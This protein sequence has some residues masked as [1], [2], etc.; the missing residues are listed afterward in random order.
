VLC[1]EPLPLRL[2]VGETSIEYLRRGTGR[3]LL[4]L[5]GFDG[6]SEAD[7]FIDRLAHDFDVV[8]PS[9]PGFGDSSLLD[10]MSSIEDLAH[11]VLALADQ[12]E[13]RNAILVGSS[14][15]GWLAAEI[16]AK[17]PQEF[18]QVILADAV[19]VRF[20]V[21]PLE[22]EIQD[23][24]TIA[25][26]DYPYAL[27][28]DRSVAEEHFGA[29]DFARMSEEAAVRFCRNREGA[30]L[31]GW[32]PLLHNPGLRQ[33]LSLIRTPTLVLWGAEDQVVSVGYGAR[34]AGS[35]PGAAF[36]VVESCG[37]YLPLERPD[38]FVRLTR[39]FCKR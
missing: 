16:A 20:A 23:I 25:T 17:R 19:G 29:L 35:I 14:F 5:H 37:H 24:F 30:T 11:F 15:G 33:R 32:A 10:T 26:A 34:F 27:F 2:N 31:F 39:E 9:L 6:I 28:H 18:S 21:D 13:L 3:S 8:A 4:Y 1:S 7:P 12:L 22:K 38:E 36:R